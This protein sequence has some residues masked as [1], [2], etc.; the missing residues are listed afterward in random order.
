[1]SPLRRIVCSIG[2]VVMLPFAIV[3]FLVLWLG[4]PV[5]EKHD[6]N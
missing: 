5:G 1:V 2:A 4:A 3:L 6:H